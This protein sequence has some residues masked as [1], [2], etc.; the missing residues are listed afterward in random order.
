[1]GYTRNACRNLVEKHIRKWPLRRLRRWEGKAD[2]K[3]FSKMEG[4]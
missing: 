3:E 4:E 1:M 2:L